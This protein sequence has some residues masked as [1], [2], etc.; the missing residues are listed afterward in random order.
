MITAL[1]TKYDPKWPLDFQK[2]LEY[3]AEKLSHFQSIEH[4]GSTSVPG[5]VAKPIIDIV[6]VVRNE[7]MNQIIRDLGAKGYRH[8]GDLG[9]PGREAFDYLTEKFGLP[10][11]HLYACYSDNEELR[12]WRAF[13]SVLLESKKLRDELSELKL[14]LVSTPNVTRKLYMEGKQQ[15]A[16]RI[17]EL[18]LNALAY[19]K[20][21]ASPLIHGKP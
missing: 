19:D 10:K 1:V 13:K 12:R 5:M 20:S 6:I 14:R 17:T 8:Q 2:I 11:H 18:G 3:V 16:K 9:I 7:K 21:S 15:L 4:L